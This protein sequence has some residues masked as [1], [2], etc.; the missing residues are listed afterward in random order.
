MVPHLGEKSHGARSGGLRRRR[1]GSVPRLRRTTPLCHAGGRRYAPGIQ[2][3][4][5]D[6]RQVK[7]ALG[8][9]LREARRLR[10][11]TL[12]EV[13]ILSDGR[14]KPSAIGGYE[15]GER[16]I[17]VERFCDLAMLYRVPADRLLGEV[18]DL[19]DPDRRME[20]VVDLRELEVLPGEESRLAAELVSRVRRQRSGEEGTVVTLRSG[21]LGALAVASRQA[22]SDLLR[23]LEPAVRV[24]PAAGEREG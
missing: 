12:R 16:S 1:S 3:A 10:G 18:L 4:A 24:R 9:V 7:E 11:L 19:L 17:T 14:F 6:A 23:R 20:I 22:T 21:D 5:A 8:E 13:S 15:R 2:D